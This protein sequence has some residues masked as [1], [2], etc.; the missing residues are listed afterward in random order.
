[1]IIA[2][3]G[4]AAHFENADNAWSVAIVGWADNGAPYVLDEDT[5]HLV[6]LRDHISALD[7]GTVMVGAYYEPPA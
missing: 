5:A 1:M 6:A 4:Y 3:P 2:P 7:P